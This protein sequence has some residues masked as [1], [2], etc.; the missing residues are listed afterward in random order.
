[1]NVIVG[2]SWS[3]VSEYEAGERRLESV[4][5]RDICVALGVN[6]VKLFRTWEKG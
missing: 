3:F 4:E 6:L 2:T 1:V 5:L